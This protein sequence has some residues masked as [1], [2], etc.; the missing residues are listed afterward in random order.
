MDY[1]GGVIV[2]ASGKLTPLGVTVLALLAERPMHPYEMFSVL[3][4][5]RQDRLVKI[6]A[7][8]LYHTV[9][10][11]ARDGLITVTGT[12]RE[13]ARPER[14]MYALADAGT[15]ALQDWVRR[16]LAEPDPEYPHFP[17]ALAEAHNLPADTVAE[18]LGEYLQVIDTEIEFDRNAI[19]LLKS[20]D[21]AEAHWLE[22]EYLLAQRSAERDWIATTMNRL[23]SK[24]LP[25]PR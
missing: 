2:E 8:S 12:E 21:L 7:G 22:L 19:E 9:E 17:V 5:R 6:R 15:F 14:T 11:M 20:R 23:Q 16:T 10:R 4:E 13:G 24:D 1:S 25:W 18:L 3:I